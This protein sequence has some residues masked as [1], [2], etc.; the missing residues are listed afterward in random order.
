MNTDAGGHFALQIAAKPLL[1]AT[2]LSLTH[3]QP[4]GTYQTVPSPTPK[5][6]GVPFSH[7]ALCYRRKTT[8]RQTD[9]WHIVA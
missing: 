4:I 6:R 3:W 9:E 5:A 1:M 7:S 2:W 8:D